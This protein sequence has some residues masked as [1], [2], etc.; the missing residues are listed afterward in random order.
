MWST[1]IDKFPKAKPMVL[2][3][4]WQIP[5][6]LT[7]C[8]GPVHASTKYYRG[9]QTN[10]KLS[11]TAPSNASSQLESEEIW[12]PFDE[13]IEEWTAARLTQY[14]GTDAEPLPHLQRVVIV[15]AQPTVGNPKVLCEFEHNNE[16]VRL[17][18]NPFSMTSKTQYKEQVREAYEYHYR[19]NE[20]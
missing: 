9:T 1:R 11:A 4:V 2:E 17:W 19:L 14:L 15:G 6:S 13:R 5:V 20:R 10:T 18:M 16:T 12:N 7:S 3:K 8:I